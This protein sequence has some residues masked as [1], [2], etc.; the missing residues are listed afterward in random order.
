MESAPDRVPLLDGALDLRLGAV[1]RHGERE[2][3]TTREQALLRYLAARPGVE[4]PRERLLE[5]VWGYAPGVQSRTVDT[6]VKRLRRKIELD[7]KAPR[8]LLSVH[9]VGYRWL[10]AEEPSIHEAPAPVP[11]LPAD[12][13][14]FVGRQAELA[15]L[16]TLEGARLVTLRGPAGVGK[17]RLAR[18]HLGA[19]GPI[20]LELAGVQ[21]EAGVRVALASALNLGDATDD[22]VAAALAGRGDVLVFVDDADGVLTFL[23]QR[24]PRLMRAAPRL[25][26]VVTARE[27]LDLPGEEVV[28]VDLLPLDDAVVLFRARARGAEATDETLAALA[29][30]LDRLPLALEL[31]AA[32]CGVLTPAELLTRL[33]QRFAL[34]ARRG[35]GRHRR[36]RDAIGWSWEQLEPPEQSA[37]AQCSVF[38]WGFDLDAAEAVLRCDDWVL[39]V[40]DSLESKS[41]LQRWVLPDAPDQGRLIL[42]DSVRVFAASQLGDDERAAA[43]ARHRA[44][45]AALG[46]ELVDALDG[47]EPASAGRRLDAEARNV[48]AA[49]QR[50]AGE[51]RARLGLVLAAALERR[52]SAQ[53]AVDVLTASDAEGLPAALRGWLLLQRGGAAVAA[54]ASGDAEADALAAEPLIVGRPELEAMAARLRGNLLFDAGD[55]PGAAACFAGALA[56]ELDELHPERLRLLVREGFAR[57]HLGELDRA[58][59]LGHEALAAAS[60]RRSPLHE[61]EARRLLSAVHLRRSRFAE[62]YAEAE[63]AARCNQELGD[64]GKE[65]LCREMLGT[66]RAFEGRHEDAC[67]LH[68]EAV[69]LH[70]R[71]GRRRELARALSNLARD[72][73]SL[74]DAESARPLVQEAVA[75]SREL[76]VARAAMELEMLQ[77]T[78]A[79]VDRD[80][81]GAA[82]HFA[83]AGQQSK[84]AGWAVMLGLARGAEALARV[85]LQE[86]GEAAR[87]NEEARGLFEAGRDRLGHCVHLGVAGVIEAEQG[88]SGADW[89]ARARAEA[90]TALG[91]RPWL[92][93]CEAIIAA[94]SG[95]VERARALTPSEPSWSMALVLSD[96]LAAA[97]AEAEQRGV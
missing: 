34:L 85:A 40:L 49:W 80:P 51:E 93:L 57:Y 91:V 90:P 55:V 53:D 29:V 56:A 5:D 94:R 63:A 27:A 69:A 75:L 39:D 21:S 61:A 67:W 62:A 78:L 2:P 74:L 18:R 12:L 66:I 77:G 79:S 6:T 89:V 14:A 82:Q 86:W 70:R 15:E 52:G 30:E 4:I 7:P 83:R 41:L 28:V 48:R 24:L 31:A 88:R 47:P 32:R 1:E 43:E 95:D 26:L 45:Y 60:R 87:L 64:Q 8:H 33:D 23:R 50:S 36:L 54:A 76:G 84:E 71:L 65:A 22:A 72:H 44:H 42:L 25:R 16:A 35:G 9:G 97:L 68:G 81:R 37:L 11:G 92:D 17:S 46:R 13:D 10:P 3:L 38:R 96:R 58:G 19:R 73:L 59:E 20:R